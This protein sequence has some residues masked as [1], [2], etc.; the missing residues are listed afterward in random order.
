[1]SSFDRQLEEELE[2]LKKKKN[3]LTVE[4]Y[5]LG[6]LSYLPSS[7][8]LEASDIAP[9]IKSRQDV[10]HDVV[11]TATQ[12]RKEE[13]EE[14]DI[15]PVKDDGLDFFQK[16]AFKDGFD[17]S[18]IPKT[19]LGTVG[20]MGLNAVKGVAGIGEGIGDLISYGIAKGVE[21]TGDTGRANSIRKN[22]SENAIDALLKKPT[23]Y[24]DQYSVLGRTSDSIFQGVGQVGAIMAT[25]GIGAAAGLGSAGVTALTTGIMG[26]SGMGSG[27]GEAYKG[28]A[29]DGEAVTYGLIAGAADAL[30]ELMFGGLGKGV[31][32]LG[33]NKGLLSVDDL[34]AKKVS[35]LFSNQ[36]AKNFAQAGIKAT[37]EGVEEVVAGIA[38]AWGK[39][40]TYSEKE[41]GELLQ[42]ENLLEQ[43][44]VGA[45]ASG[46]AQAPSLHVANKTKAD[47]VTGQTQDEQAVVKKEIENRISEME[48]DGKKLTSKEKA[49]IEAQVE[50]AL[51]RGE[52]SLDTIEEV[53]GGDDFTAL[54]DTVTK[55][56][57]AL[58]ELA[59]LYE[60]D[61][62]KAHADSLL[63]DSKRG[64]LQ[65]KLYTSVFEKAKGS[66]LGESYRHLNKFQAD[67]TK[68]SEKEQAIIKKAVDSGV[69]ND[70]RKTH[71]FVDF[72]AKVSSYSGIDF[73]FTNNQ[74]LKETGFVFNGNTT[75][76][77]YDP[78]TNKVVINSQAKKYLHSLVGHEV[79]H[80]L[81]GSGLYESVEKIA[82][83]YAKQTKEYKTRL[84]AAHDMYSGK[85]GYTGQDGLAKI[86]KEAVA[87]M[88][89]DYLF[90]DSKFVSHLSVS[91]PN[92]FERIYN[93]VKHLWK[94]ATAG[95]QQ[96]KQLEQL[97]YTFEKALRERGNVSTTT[98]G[99]SDVRYSIRKEAPPKK[100]QKAYKLM[101]LVDGKLYPLFIG[102]NEEVTPGIW[103]NADS[104]NLS[105]LKDLEPGTHLVDMKSG[106]AMT[107]DEYAE[108]YVPKK[109][110][111]PARNKPNK[112]DVHW[113]ND[114]GYR[115][116]HIEDK[117][118]SKSEGR[119]QKQ[120][121]DTRAYYNWGVNGSSKS[122]TGE[123]SASLYA[124]RPGWHFGEVPSM[125]Q[126]G[127]GGD[128]G[129]TV[130]LDNQVWVEVEM[131]ADVD[132]NA[133]AEANW[134]GDI[135]THIPTDGYY[136]FATN[137]TQK[138]TK[139]GDTTN[140]ATKADWFVAGAFK[141]NRILSDVEADSVVNEYNRKNGRNVPLD[142]RR[143]GGRVFNAETMQVEDAVQYSLSP[144]QE[145]Y[146]KDS[147]VRDENGN[148]KVMYHGTSRG[149]HT[150]FDPYGKAKYGLFGLGSYFTDNKEVAQ[151]YTKKGKGTSPQVYE[152]YLNITNPMDMDAAA[153]PKQW[154]KAFPDA[155]FPE[156]G[157]NEQFYRAMEEYFEDNEYVRW[158]AEEAAMDAIMGMGYDGITHIGGGRFNKADDT[159][160]RVYIAFQPEQIKDVG[161][162]KPTS[163]PDIRYS[164]SQDT[165]GNKLTEEQERYFHNSK[166][167]DE[168]GNLKVMYHGSKDGGFHVFDKRYSDDH[169][170][171]FFVD[172]NDVASSYSG[173]SE[174]YAAR[175]FKTA[176]DLNQFF[177]E[178]EK[179][180][181]EV[182]EE[183]GKFVFSENGDF[184]AE[185]DTA[186][187]IY[188]EFCDWEG[189]GY[190][191]VNYKVYLNLTNPLEVD[192]KGREWDEIQIPE[193]HLA[194]FNESVFGKKDSN[195]FS[196][197]ATT[198]NFSEYANAQGYDGVIFKNILD[199][200]GYG[201]KYDPHTVAIAF[202]GSQVKSVANQNPTTNKD[203]RYSL[204]EDTEGRKLSKEQTVYF[205]D[206]KAVDENGRLKVVYHGTRNADFTVFKRNVNFFTDSKEMADSYSPNGGMYEGYVNITKPYV[207]DAA[208]EKWSKIP[209]DDATRK[210][211]QEYGASVF[212]EGGKWRTTP[213]DIASAIEEAVD[214][215][216]MDY[217]G[218]IIKNV[219]DTGSYY[220][221]NDKHIAT[222]YI[223]FNSNQFKNADNTKPTADKDIRFS[224]SE[225]TK[226]DSM[227]YAEITE[228]QQ[229]IHQR[230]MNLEERK[231]EAS[232]NPALLQAMDDYSNLF[233][234]VR[235][236]LTKKRNGTATPLEL[237]RIEEIKA[238]KEEYLQRVADLQESLGLNAIAQEETEIRETV[239]ALRV[240][241]DA[242]WAREGAEKENKAIERAGMSAPDYFRKKA[243]KA[244][245]TTI[246][247]NEAGY[248]LPDGKMLNFSG[249]ERNHRYRDHREIGE[250]YEA[251]NGVAALNRF[252]NDG[253]I[254][255]MAESPGIDLASGMEPTK[256][257]YLAI[258][259]FINANGVKDG[260]FFVD[261]S[262]K[263][264]RR[265]GNYA[266]QERVNAD[267]IISDIKHFYATG[268]IREQSLLDRFHYSLSEN[269]KKYG[270]L[271]LTGE[272]IRYNPERKSK[273]DLPIR[274]D[275]APVRKEAKSSVLYS[276]RD[277]KNGWGEVY[278]TAQEALNDAV[279]YVSRELYDAFNKEVDNTPKN[280][281]LARGSMP[282]T[283][284]LIAVQE[285]VRQESITPMQGAQ[286][287]SE[288]YMQGGAEALKQMVNQRNGNLYP[289]Y[290]EKA[291]QYETVAP[292][293]S[294]RYSIEE[295]FPD[296]LAPVQQELSGLLERRDA[297]E[298]E[299]LAAGGKEDFDT[300]YKLN[301]EY[302]AIND[303]IEELDSEERAAD[304]GRL[305]SL[306]DADAPPEMS[307][308]RDS[309]DSDNDV[310]DPMRGRLRDT[311]D[312][313]SAKPFMAER[314]EVK[315]FFQDAAR[316]MLG[317]VG[318]TIRGERFYSEEAFMREGNE[319]AWTGVSRQ[320]TADIAELRDNYGYSYNQIEN[321]LKAIIEDRVTE[322][323]LAA[324]NIEFM[325]ND[326]LLNGY[327]DMW[328][329]P[330]PANQEYIQLAWE[331]S[332][333]DSRQ[334]SFDSYMESVEGN[335]PPEAIGPVAEQKV[336][337]AEPIKQKQ[338]IGPVKEKYEA[339]TPKKQ[340]RMVKAAPEAE[341]IAKI[342]D[343]EPTPQ[344]KKNRAW[345]R[346]KANVL[347]K[348]AVFEDL[349]L[350]TRNRELMG[351]WNF[352]LGSE[353]RAQRLMGTGTEEVKSLNAIRDEVE[354]SGKAKQFYDYL[355]HKHNVDRMQLEERY[356]DMENKPVFGY[357][358]TA[359]KSQV[360]VDKYE[361]SHPSFKQY[362]QDIYD[363]MN[364]LRKLMVDNGVISQDTADLW[365]DMYP[366]YVPIRRAGKN[367]AAVNVPLDT[368]RTGVNAPVKKA[369]GG[370][371]DILPLFDTMA[372]RTVQ[373]YK[374]IA[375]NSF[376]VELKNVLGTIVE[377]EE[378]NVDGMIDSVEQQ[379]GLLQEGKNG[380]APTF[381][382]FENGEKVTFEITEDMYDALKPVSEGLAYTNKVANTISNF[383]RGLLTEYNPV[384]ML[385][386]AI[387]DTQ[388]ILINSQHPGRTY[389]KLGE[390]YA[391]MLK[392]GYWY[393]E[394]MENGGEQNT[395]FDDREISFD[396]E[397]KGVSKL[398]DIPPIST[399][400]K[401]NNFIEMTPRLAEYI[402][403]R[404][405]GRSIEVSMLDAARVTTN[406]QAGGDLTKFLNRN[407]AT[408]LNAS[409]Q[410]LMQN[411]RNFREAK[412]NGWKGWANL[413]TKFA[414]AGLPAVL[415]NGLLWDDDEEYEELSDY[416]KQNYYIVAK[417][418]D[419]KFVRIPK[420]R[421]IAVIQAGIEQIGNALTGD[422]EVDLNSFL[423]LV[424]SNLA[425][426]NPIEDN[427]LAPIIQVKN[428][429]TWYG[430]DL[431]PTRLQDLPAAEQYDESTDKLSKWLG[432]KL[433]ISP[434]KINYLLDQYTGG[435]GDT[436]LPMLTPEAESGDNSA[437]GNLLAP[438]KSKFT[439]DSVMNN[440]NVSDFYD[441]KDELTTAAK[442]AKA[443]DTDV[444]K[445]K[446]MN[447]VNAELS[448][449][450]KQKREIQNSGLPDSVKYQRV[451]AIQQ[452]IVDLTKES[453]DAYDN[454]T[455][456][457]DIA[458]I[459][460]RY[461]ERDDEGQWQK[462][463]DS[464]VAKYKA[465]SAAGDAAYATD[466]TNH[467]RW[468]EPGEDSDGEPGWRKVSDKELERQ[469]EVTSGLGITPEEY[470]AKQ[471]EYSYAYE[472][473]ENYAVAKSVGGYEAYRTYSSELYEIKADKDE[474]GKSISGSRKDKVIDYVS[475]LDIDYGMK[476]ILFKSEYN[477]DDTYNNEIIDYL[478]SRSDLSFDD[479]A[480]ILRK[481]GFEVSQDGTITW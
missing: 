272:E 203:I 245:K 342:L 56:N 285:D 227:S 337:K 100:T 385:T 250:I 201:G 396:T 16:G 463:S 478:N 205:Q 279:Q 326:R 303:R 379:E 192:A 48:K 66:R 302:T 13:E 263:D 440:Q 131:S 140:D 370:N 353:A 237:A 233:T 65:E 372:L 107:W 475:N 99:D 470:W 301:E 235:G 159:R 114:N 419:G 286:L 27:M 31:N 128:A 297:L 277:G 73:E 169:T 376:G 426:N 57:E 52:I 69:L 343:A 184:I 82:F 42:D 315:P 25:G 452:Q 425:P 113:A 17:W 202:D 462:M 193:E 260:R 339:I 397:R 54:R 90:T 50:E 123:G 142:Y 345:A 261:F 168:N 445:N 481:I 198:R 64:E 58:A 177:A 424:V 139:K 422:D 33:F 122:Q 196:T 101:R 187:G 311:E 287:L 255:V 471:E 347:D 312:F 162:Q 380:A 398:L 103:Y 207:I 63:K 43:F 365:A 132:Y 356:E 401:L 467:Y 149:G 110:G 222:D 55:E 194:K 87:D 404:E 236:L 352:I 200:G 213:A 338:D 359:E 68:Y 455:M 412:A 443:T 402:A 30:T 417:Y 84:K 431:V 215:G 208:G 281:P 464:Q 349:S 289:Q 3:S 429:E 458:I 282:I 8:K 118:G 160:H 88:I 406:F 12:K 119:M 241:S 151:S 276:M 418:G 102:N 35:N 292:D 450:Y 179:P 137:P 85:E 300:F 293:E 234:E 15:A 284:A 335:L 266:Y 466:G 39:S 144:Q 164:L 388:D 153:D 211:L 224:L 477:A 59:E 328:G 415:L 392:K 95:S 358:V 75:N 244:F 390:A 9:V 138:K 80:A 134:G 76:G 375:K 152:T 355:Y 313:K 109:D 78:K 468:Y 141:V 209:I 108:K 34:L 309:L 175:S 434:V 70:S 14:E 221:G 71:E 448:E 231:R 307:V 158:E 304:E 336:Y 437:V 403:S 166:M 49:E 2:K 125:H 121:G 180:W 189:V 96:A 433:D 333:N 156:S 230:K 341:K 273:Y 438:L 94:M 246:N 22:A 316:A 357:S 383:H 104:P 183:N 421:T 130:R 444:L 479:I 204:S 5:G 366:N 368:G 399:I 344:N 447:S 350:K 256:E 182:V 386:N 394:Y 400:G 290:L 190:G 436:I 430:E 7:T 24:L 321:A 476:L 41:L 320:T 6:R 61:E 473:P 360:I 172:S 47:F 115:F 240:A 155:K 465:T 154:Q 308:T 351:K 105:Q 79:T 74:R 10:F 248:L 186:L 361:I 218:I 136:K 439:T 306:E 21:A 405:A 334:D 20:D 346:F 271:H 253:N 413:A 265:A 37:A 454:I 45:V 461:F 111:K 288:A 83:E 278:G 214:N 86:K 242:A 143:N 19:I 332:A 146:F 32:A 262:D 29:T 407:G 296:D 226:Y 442:S 391:Q 247:F 456:K 4:N 408:F 191:D 223:V 348:G 112:D 93:E 318:E 384:F 330:M 126:I 26:A 362:A 77:F 416:V 171:F 274:Q 249:G 432:E 395:Y 325:L 270:D 210:F 460:N 387:K 199:V 428:N 81:E 283:D 243:L 374:A 117:A 369:T 44:I 371:M 92:V 176:E 291:K 264:G 449:L 275:I 480:T 216:D 206:S 170:S 212:K 340:P 267:R 280:T 178:I 441:T 329:E 423:E 310:P 188:E 252:L 410:G 161:N 106:E 91:N 393:T 474:N 451:R 72:V 257:Q 319:A 174:T 238:L 299:M 220:K 116:M 40:A 298:A 163:D 225:E 469:N 11:K 331:M 51:E 363:Y 327:T 145:E 378:T 46:F 317:D 181:Y 314:P 232:N 135:P 38:Q 36:I 457:G 148:L 150:M 389:L 197:T 167:R 195:G 435:V 459:G 120:Y 354:S 165:E 60:G 229:K 377:H 129:E 97:K 259:R 472:H 219:D 89:G 322:R 367:G 53:L 254:R 67:L 157:T 127:Y 62:L 251:T 453:L 98:E 28:G 414:V 324:K 217:D 268:Q 239:E 185:S 228:E 446:Y 295:M 411:V 124:L 23:D 364:H 173:T 373:T 258:R 269:G 427:I 133:E 305:A 382:V 420:G 323:H 1:M 147:V 381:T 18:D 294:P 409:V